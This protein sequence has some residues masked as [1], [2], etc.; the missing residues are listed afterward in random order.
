MLLHINDESA[1]TNADSRKPLLANALFTDLLADLSAELDELL[2]SKNMTFLEVMNSVAVRS[3]LINT[4]KDES[5]NFP[6]FQKFKTYVSK[7][8][9]VFEYCSGAGATIPCHCATS[10]TGSTRPAAD[11]T[12]STPFPSTRRSGHASGQSC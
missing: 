4:V 9:V 7:I 3:V 12:S 1:I 2:S 5:G 8:V 6:I 11:R 10:T